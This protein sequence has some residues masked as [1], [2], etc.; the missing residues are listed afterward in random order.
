MSSVDV[1]CL[2]DLVSSANSNSCDVTTDGKSLIKIRKS[3]GPR[4]LPCGTPESTGEVLDRLL[5]TETHWDRFC[6]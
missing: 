3:R 4:I 1:I 6:K 5:S 2:K